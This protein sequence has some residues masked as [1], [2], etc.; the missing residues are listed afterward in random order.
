MIR[1]ALLTLALFAGALGQPGSWTTYGPGCPGRTGVPQISVT[2]SL[3]PGQ[4]SSLHAEASSPLPGRMSLGAVLLGD[5]ALLEGP[6]ALVI[7]RL[8]VVGIGAEGLDWPF[9]PPAELGGVTVFVQVAELDRASVLG[10]SLTPG[11]ALTIG[12][13]P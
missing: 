3:A 4:I 10:F 6:L 8:A 1:I 12:G 11:L 13:A 9:C 7:R 2:G 5:R